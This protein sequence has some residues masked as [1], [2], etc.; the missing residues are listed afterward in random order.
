MAVALLRSHDMSW[1]RR[2][3][4]TFR[5]VGGFLLSAAVR[6]RR[7]AR[8]HRP[9]RGY[10][11]EI[12]V[13]L[14]HRVPKWTPSV[15]RRMRTP[16]PWMCSANLHQGTSSR[17]REGLGGCLPRLGRGSDGSPGNAHTSA[18]P[19]KSG[20]ARSPAGTPRSIPAPVDPHADVAPAERVRG[21]V[22]RPRR[23]RRRPRQAARPHPVAWMG[24][25]SDGWNVMRRYAG[26][27]PC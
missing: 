22:S 26:T 13:L 19:P 6:G 15:S 25:R 16:D 21:P 5:R 20:P 14:Q 17:S 18:F 7:P 10:G 1:A 8:H 23:R 11:W 4:P 24:I 9:V 12:V 2:D 3:H 27:A